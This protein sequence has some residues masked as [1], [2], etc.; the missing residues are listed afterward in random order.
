MKQYRLYNVTLTEDQLTMID[1]WAACH[2]MKYDDKDDNDLINDLF[3][4]L[5]R[6][7]EVGTITEFVEEW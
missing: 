5:Y 6:A 1:G 2:K 3:G 7:N 4:R